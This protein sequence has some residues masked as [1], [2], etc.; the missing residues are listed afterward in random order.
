MF[1]LFFYSLLRKK[2]KNKTTIIVHT[3]RFKHDNLWSQLYNITYTI[4]LYEYITIN[5]DTNHFVA[6]PFLR[7]DNEL[8]RIQFIFIIILVKYSPLSR[9][10]V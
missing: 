2:Y 8:I 10:S 3:L 9:N 6:A 1:Y 7:Y 5:V 4:Y